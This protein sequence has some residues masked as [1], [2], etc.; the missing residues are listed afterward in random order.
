MNACLK[1]GYNYR[2]FL[3]II[4]DYIS[5]REVKLWAGKKKQCSP[6]VM[7][8]V[9]LWQ[10]PFSRES[11]RERERECAYVCMREKERMRENIFFSECDKD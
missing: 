1:G 8:I 11:E 9:T 10:N 3:G 4:D 7:I 5:T 6:R 2:P